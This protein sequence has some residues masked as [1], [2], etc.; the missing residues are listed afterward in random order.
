MRE[1]SERRM[2]KEQ[3]HKDHH[4]YTDFKAKD[5]QTQDQQHQGM[6]QQI[7][8]A[9]GSK[10][11][12]LRG[13]L[14]DKYFLA[15]LVVF[16]AA[17]FV[18][19]KYIGQESIWNDAAVHLWYAIKVTKEPLFFFSREY[20]LGDHVLTQTVSAFFYL[21]TQNAF[22]AGKIMTILFGMAGIFV[23]YLLARELGGKITGIICAL[24][25]GFHHLLWFYGVRP[26][27]DGPLTAFV[28]FLL[29]AVLK[30]ER[31]KSM[32]WGGLTALAFLLAMTIK[33]QAVIFFLAYLCYIVIVQR[34]IAI[35]SRP[36]LL[37]WLLPLG[38]LFVAGIIFGQNFLKAAIVR[39]VNHYGLTDGSIYHVY[40]HLQWIF[41]WY[42]L[43]PLFLGII[44]IVAYKKKDY[45]FSAILF[46]FSVIYMEVGIRTIEDRIVMNILAA[47][48]V[49]AVLCMEE[50]GRMIDV[51]LRKKNIGII[52]VMAFSLFV[53]YSFYNIGDY[54]ILNKATTYAGHE[55]AGNWIK[56]H[57][58][59]A[60]PVFAG[61]PR[62]Q[63]LFTEREYAGPGEWT[64]GG[65]LWYLRA[66]EYLQ[67]RG[68]FEEHLAMLAAE[69]DVYLEID[70]W[71]YTQ[72][73]WY[74]P[75]SQESLNYFASL[76]FSIVHIV[77]R[78]VPTDKGIQKVPVIFILKK[79]KA[80]FVENSNTGGNFITGD[81]SII[82]NQG[83]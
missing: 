30:L 15:F 37:S 53:A 49:L 83:G 7:H 62:T 41:S 78:E 40:Q 14:R 76:G 61:S 31:T 6:H 75:I 71:E 70:I 4:A 55:E 66:D 9:E 22:V 82:V 42:L 74:F 18:R 32:L 45:Y 17:L 36:F 19:L 51:F 12:L 28:V 27:A 44:L 77:E 23:M 34:K 20:L 43:I 8:T 68:L 24:L 2:N 79:D 10:M 64:Q 48:I 59:A 11:S 56:E 35:T 46:L 81:N 65:M 38:L 47:G 69:H 54:L 25:F 60:D 57:V 1:E 72:P 16:A 67:N 58:P 39:F 63:R 80:A 13:V 33:S 3:T 29:Y 52:I 5:L 73:S 50:A 26:L 21:F